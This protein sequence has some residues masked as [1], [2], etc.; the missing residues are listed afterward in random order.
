[1]DNEDF[2]VEKDPVTLNL[3]QETVDVLPYE[4]IHPIETEEEQMPTISVLNEE[5]IEVDSESALAPFGQ[6][7]EEMN[8]A[9]L[10]NRDA[11]NQHPIQAITGLEAEL[12]QIK[13]P[14]TVYSD[15]LGHA[16]YFLWED[17]NSGHDNRSGF[18][19]PF[20]KMKIQSRYLIVAMSLVSQ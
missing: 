16:N 13:S 18:L 19:Y 15:K 2:I 4:E 20:V 1:M 17:E 10:N 6:S 8:H 11:L 7:N 14:H 5:V 9:K 12:T 3:E